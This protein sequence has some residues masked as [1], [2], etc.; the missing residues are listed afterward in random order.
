MAR[1]IRC[2]TLEFHLGGV[3]EII[4]IVLIILA[5]AHIGEES[6]TGFTRFLNTRWFAGTDSCPVPRWKSIFIDKLGLFAALTL[7]AILGVTHDG[8][9]I[10]ISVGIII[11]DIVQHVAF[12]VG[13][14]GYT[15]GIA[16]S[17]LY[18]ALIVFFFSGSVWR[19]LLSAPLGWLALIAGMLFI[20]GN[21]LLAW[22]TV[23]LGLCRPA[24]H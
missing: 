1:A 19:A 3:V 16:T 9:W 7:F 24:S 5:A 23:R 6:A 15:P 8:R 22:T 20:V 2:A 4:S 14:R 12:S 13:A 21:Y 10:L 17:V 11:A 18:L